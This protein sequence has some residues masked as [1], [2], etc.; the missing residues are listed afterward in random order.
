M[1]ILYQPKGTRILIGEDADKYDKTIRTLLSEAPGS[2]AILP[3]IDGGEGYAGKPGEMMRVVGPSRATV[4]CPE[5]TDQC[6]RIARELNGE[7]LT[8]KYVE[9]CY[10]LE[11]PQ[12]GR[13]R[14]FTQFGVEWLNQ[15]IPVSDVAAI[16]YG[17]CLSIGL[18]AET[19]SE[20]TGI[21]RGSD[22]YKEGDTFE[23]RASTLTESQSQVVGG[24]RYAEGIGFAIGVDRAILAAE[25]VAE[26]I[27]QTKPT[28]P[29]S[30]CVA[31]GKDLASEQRRKAAAISPYDLSRGRKML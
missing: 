17:L 29:V 14:E 1:N 26:G 3:A 13:W 16:A 7:P 19:L 15:E 31:V 20:T 25:K 9:R 30:R 22:Y 5:R 2:L 12:S 8:I 23:I 21:D 11:R 27:K 6:R 4:L 10:R 24:G 18:N 28:T